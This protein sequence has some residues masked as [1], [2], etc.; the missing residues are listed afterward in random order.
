MKNILLAAQY[1]AIEIY[2]A[3]AERLSNQ[4]NWVFLLIGAA[5][6]ALVLAF[7]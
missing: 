4:P 1:Y 2:D 6:C 5:V 7:I 3:L